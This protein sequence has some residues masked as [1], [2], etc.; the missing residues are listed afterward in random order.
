MATSQTSNPTVAPT[1]HSKIR[2]MQLRTKS[3]IYR[4]PLRGYTR[5]MEGLF[6]RFRPRTRITTGEPSMA[7]SESSD[8]DSLNSAWRSEQ[9]PPRPRAKPS[10]K[11]DVATIPTTGFNIK[12]TFRPVKE[13]I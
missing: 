3:L 4:E 13:D 5:L 8:G 12:I 1:L 7:F 10:H 6:D 11:K 9:C 2:A